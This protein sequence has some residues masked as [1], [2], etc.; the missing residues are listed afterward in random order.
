MQQL[1]G[2]EL[3]IIPV[4]KKAHQEHLDPPSFVPLWAGGPSH[5][6]WIGENSP[7]SYADIARKK[8]LDSPSSSDDDPISKKGGR[9]YKKE[10]WEEEAEG[11][12]TQ[13]SQSTIEMSYGRNK[14]TRPP[15]GVGTPS[16]LGK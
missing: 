6:S 5:S 15:K 7:P 2:D 11:L 8:Q 1:N 9:K 4:P 14:K 10:I 3:E 13:G 12:K 16:Q